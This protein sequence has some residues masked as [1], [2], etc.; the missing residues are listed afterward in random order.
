MLVS[1]DPGTHIERMLHTLRQS[2][3][4]CLPGS[5]ELR[6]AHIRRLDDGE[7]LHAEAIERNGAEKRVAI[8]FGPES[9]AVT[10]NLAFN[11]T[12]E[13][14]HARYA[15]LYVFGFAA[16]PKALEFHP[17]RADKRSAE[18]HALE[19]NLLHNGAAGCAAG[20][21]KRIAV[22]VIDERGNELPVIAP[23]REGLRSTVLVDFHTGRTLEPATKSH[24]NAW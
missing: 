23:G 1:A 2:K 10:G 15:H 13:A 20:P 18:D 17:R 7:H 22:K 3:T 21:Q 11:A 5:R 9:G 4:L 24:V 6:F 19:R 12:S 14:R 16:D 8:V